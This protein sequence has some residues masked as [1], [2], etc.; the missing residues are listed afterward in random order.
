MYKLEELTEKCSTHEVSVYFYSDTRKIALI[1]NEYG[2]IYVPK[3][4]N[5]S[6]KLDEEDRTGE[7]GTIQLD[8]GFKS[9]YADKELV[10]ISVLIDDKE[11]YM[12]DTH[13]LKLNRD[14]ALLADIGIAPMSLNS[15]LKQ[16]K[17]KPYQMTD[18]ELYQYFQKLDI[19]TVDYNHY[20]YIRNLMIERN[21]LDGERLKLTAIQDML[22]DFEIEEIF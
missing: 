22:D 11:F 18:T 9:L 7:D 16:H 21:M 19:E 6:E 10:P 5:W 8:S 3:P 17:Q 1:E 13:L 12:Y 4:V 20:I 14:N 15:I 2:T